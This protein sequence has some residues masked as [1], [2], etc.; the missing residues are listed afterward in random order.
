MSASTSTHRPWLKYLMVFLALSIALYALAYF[1]VDRMA[2][3][4]TKPEELFS[5]VLWRTAF[6]AHVGLA[7]VALATGSV[8]FFPQW[9]NR[10]LARHRFLGK[11]YLIAV[12]L[13]GVAVLIAVP[14]A[15]GDW[16]TRLGFSTLAVLWL[17]SGAVAYNHIRHGRVSDHERWL[18]V[19]YALTF[20]A[21]TLRLWMPVLIGGFGLAFLDAYR[22]VA[23]LCWVPNLAVVAFS[24]IGQTPP[25]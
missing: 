2:I 4:Q 23:W 8:Q 17:I 7:A 9:R 25:A 5:N 10:N 11:I 20:A 15:T 1:F 12:M 16:I 18:I 3:L 19:T 6:F 13:S 14:N 24:K 21:V 22:I